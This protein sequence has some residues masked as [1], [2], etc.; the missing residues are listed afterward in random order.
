MDWKPKT[1]VHDWNLTPAVRAGLIVRSLK[2][3]TSLGDWLE[4]SDPSIRSNHLVF[5]WYDADH[6]GVWGRGET[7]DLQLVLPE[8]PDH[9]IELDAEVSMFIADTLPTQQVDVFV[10]V[11][12][13]A[14]W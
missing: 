2:Y 11:E 5:G 14:T 12:K 1:P 8:R 7:H 9:D 6:W 4:V 10:A 13:L 3:I